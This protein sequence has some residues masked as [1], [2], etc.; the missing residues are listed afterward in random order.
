MGD[1]NKRPPQ[2]DHTPVSLAGKAI[3]VAG[4]TSGI[5]LATARLLG[6]QGARVFIFG[7]DET[8]LGDARR[9][10]EDAGGKAFGTTADQSKVEEVRR[11][12]EEVDKQLG[13]IDILVNCAAVETEGVM[14]GQLE[15]M[16]YTVQTNL[17]GYLACSHEALQRMKQQRSGH[18]IN[19]GS[20]SAEA[21]EE[22]GDVY[23][24]T[25]AAIQGFSG[26]LRK[27]ANR[28][29]IRVTL[30]EPG[31]I[32]TPLVGESEEAKQKQKAQQKIL[33]P[34]DIAESVLY[35]LTQPQRCDVVSVQV[36]PIRQII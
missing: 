26:S 6:A 17:F 11:I 28:E 4:G 32:D 3:V 35:C 7:R 16:L 2:W 36:R 15:D 25:K 24:S 30:I 13:S 18:I 5:G 19:I 34:E 12:F 22:S 21:R 10:I 1:L 9:Q 14:E 20:M 27:S 8:E 23:V 33:P 29:G 31:L